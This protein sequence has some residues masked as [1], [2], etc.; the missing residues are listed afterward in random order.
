MRRIATRIMTAALLVVL[1][2][3]SALAAGDRS[4]PY[5]ASIAAGDALMRTGPGQ[6]YPSTWR[7]RRADLP[8]Q[9]V[10]VH[11]SWRRVRAPDGTEGWFASVLLSARRTAIVTGDIRPMHSAPD[12]SARVLWRAEPGVVGRL[13][14]CAAGW[15]E[16]DVGGRVGYIQTAHIWGVGAD[17]AV[18]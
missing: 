14:H 16:F 1:A 9:V 7:F 2:G 3:P 17:E 15:C 10:Q 8:I 11:E 4:V 12:R 13:A 18:D 6:N 5:W